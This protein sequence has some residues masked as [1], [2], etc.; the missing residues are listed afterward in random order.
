MKIIADTV[1]PLPF[2]LHFCAE[3]PEVDPLTTCIGGFDATLYFPPSLGDGTDG[4]GL[5]GSW[6]WWTG[7][8]LRL[9]L[10][11]ETE[12]LD[13][14]GVARLHARACDAGTHL[15]RGFL[16][17]CRL[18]LDRPEIHP[19]TIDPSGLEL[20]EVRDDGSMVTLG[21][22]GSGSFFD[23][24]PADPPLAT[25]INRSTLGRLKYEMESDAA[26]PL[27]AMLRLDARLLRSQGEPE[28]AAAIET[29]ASTFHGQ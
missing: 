29:L 19:V 24:L 6:A 25:S 26:P 22:P 10:E 4:K 21:S 5:F 8:S 13:D 18:Q 16:N 12:E 3:G 27:A 17:A 23:R 2:A 15:L 9:V 14:D 1:V 28:R 20:S 7:T 11:T